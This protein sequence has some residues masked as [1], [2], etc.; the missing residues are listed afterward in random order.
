MR[1][2]G[3]KMRIYVVEVQSPLKAGWNS[4]FLSEDWP[5]AVGGCGV[6]AE[7]VK[8]RNNGFHL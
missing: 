6:T 4:L 5:G 2:Y 1:G 7:A 3:V 8:R